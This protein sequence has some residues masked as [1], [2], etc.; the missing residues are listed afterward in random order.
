MPLC[1][2]ALAMDAFAVYLILRFCSALFF[3]LIFTVNMLYQVTVVQLT[4]LQLVLVGTILEATVFIFEI[5]TGILADVKS[6]RLSVIIGHALMGLGFVVEG[7]VPVF[8]AVALAQVLWGFGY[9]FTS[10]ATQAWIVDEIGE[11]RAGE[12]FLRGSQA[13]QA[14]RLIAIPISIAL[15]SVLVRLPVLLGGGSMIL[16]AIFLAL[17][18][19]EEGFTPTPPEDRTTW[20]MMLR[21]V[22]DAQRM[23][24]RQPLLLALLGIGLFYGLYSEGLDRLWTPHLLENFVLPSWLAG[25]DAVVWFGVVRGV[26]AIV[27]LVAT[28]VVRRR[29]DMNR[30]ASLGQALMW[31]TGGI[32]L[33]LAGFGLTRSFWVAVALYWAVGVLRGIHGPLSS[34]WFN[35]RIDDPQVRATMFSVQGQVDAIGQITSGPVVGLIGNSS[36]RAALVASAAI[37]SPVLPLYSMVIR[38]GEHG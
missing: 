27:S 11:E 1:H 25:T 15:G 29:V 4:P 28:E 35:G 24:R 10:G 19:T 17:T 2:R 18:M 20:A 7:S 6:R 12:A 37:L 34:T 32:I 22:Q 30:W 21:T 9:T 8:G 16:L 38:R 26:L 5:P 33:A 23:V 14:G 31:N 36:I 3:S 13:G